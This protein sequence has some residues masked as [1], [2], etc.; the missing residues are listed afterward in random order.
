MPKGS[1]RGCKE[2]AADRRNKTFELRRSGATY[3]AITTELGISPSAAFI[4]V[5]TVMSELK[6]L[7]IEEAEDYR[8]MEL[9]RLDAIQLALMPEVNQGNFKAIDRYLRI[10]E[11]RCKLLGLYN[12]PIKGASKEQ[13]ISDRW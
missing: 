5:K 6:K 9:E 2:N 1:P 13:E 10:S 4:D 8:T 12:L 11:S 3:R 7:D